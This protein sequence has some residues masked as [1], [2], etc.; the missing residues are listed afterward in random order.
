M[1]PLKAKPSIGTQEVPLTDGRKSQDDFNQTDDQ[2]ADDVVK[3]FPNAPPEMA[4][5]TML[6]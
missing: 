6:T 1:D 2:R 4:W 3:K 5:I